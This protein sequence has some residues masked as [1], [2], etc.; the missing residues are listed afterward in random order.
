MKKYILTIPLF[1]SCVFSFGQ[2]SVIQTFIA[3][4][5][6]YC[7]TKNIKITNTTNKDNYLKLQASLTGDKFNIVIANYTDTT[8]YFT[9]TDGR[10]PIIQEILVDNGNWKPIEDYP[11]SDCG[12]SFKKLDLGEKRLIECNGYYYKGD[13]KTKLRFHLKIN[14]EDYYS[15]PIETLID[16]KL[17]G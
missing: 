15:E 4:Q 16:Y 9:T 13:I 5:K 10:L 11:D 8:I 6:T 7:V 3:I 17:K 2:T 1:F 12:M 14:N